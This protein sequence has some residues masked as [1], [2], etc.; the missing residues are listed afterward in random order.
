MSFRRVSRDRL[1]AELAEAVQRLDVQSVHTILFT[2]HGDASDL[3]AVLGT[4]PAAQQLRQAL[5]EDYRTWAAEMADDDVA[6][7]V[8]AVLMVLDQPDLWAGVSV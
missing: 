8:P 7:E 1:R 4:S 3:D 2:N 5:V 6:V